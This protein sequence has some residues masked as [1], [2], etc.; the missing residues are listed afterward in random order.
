MGSCH[1]RLRLHPLRAALHEIVSW[2]KWSHHV[3]SS[4]GDKE[5]GRSWWTWELPS[6]KHTKNYGKSPFLNGKIHYKCGIFNSKLLN[7]QRVDWLDLDQPL[8]HDQHWSASFSTK[9]HA[10]SGGSPING[11]TKKWFLSNRHV[12]GCKFLSKKRRNEF[13]HRSA[14]AHAVMAVLYLT[15]G[16][17]C[18]PVGWPSQIHDWSSKWWGMVH[19][20]VV[21]RECNPIGYHDLGNVNITLL[22]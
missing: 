19:I 16:K 6:G 5:I 15:P 14:A 8:D 18:E 12:S 9:K 2:A 21:Y 3:P 1:C 20:P 11:R 10:E 13:C 17:I 7:Y 4:P 22:Q